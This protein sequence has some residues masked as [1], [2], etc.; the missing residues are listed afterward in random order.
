MS[1]RRWRLSEIESALR[2][3]RSYEWD[4]DAIVEYLNA[5]PQDLPPGTGKCEIPLERG[6]DGPLNIGQFISEGEGEP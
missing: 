2:A 5:L 6:K 1:E 4:W 3:L